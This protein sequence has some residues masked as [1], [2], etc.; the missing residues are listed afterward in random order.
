VL[1]ALNV[2]ALMLMVDINRPVEGTIHESQ[3]PMQRMLLRLKANVADH[4]PAGPQR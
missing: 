2:L 1:L 3:E 4:A